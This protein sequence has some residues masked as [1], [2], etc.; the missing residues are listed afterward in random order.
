[1][2][3]KGVATMERAAVLHGAV[4]QGA[5]KPARLAG[6]TY[7][8]YPSDEQEQRFEQ[9]AGCCRA[10][11]NA[12]LEQRR[13]AWKLQRLSIWANQQAG[14]LPALKRDP[15]FAWLAVVPPSHT[16]QQ[17]L[18]DLDV[19]YRRFFRGQGGFPKFK[20]KGAGDSFRIPQPC[21][22][23]VRKLNRKWAEVRVPK[24]GW[25]RF[26]LTRPIGGDIRNAT[27]SKTAHGWQV[28]FCVELAGV[29]PRAPKRAV[30]LDRGVVITIA[31]SDGETLH[32]PRPSKHQAERRLRLE[33]KLSRQRKGSGG[34][35]RTKV[36]LAKHRATQARRS[37]DFCH[38]A[39]TEIARGYD[40]VA[41]EDLRVKNMTRSAKGSLEE[42][43][44]NV[45][46][47][48]GLNRGILEQC[49]GEIRR[50]LQYKTEWHGGALV[51]VPAAYS[52]LTC[53]RCNH[54]EG[55]NRKSQAVFICVNCGHERNADIN[56]ARV[57]LARARGGADSTA[58]GQDV[59]ARGAFGI[60]R[61]VKR[62][63]PVKQALA[64]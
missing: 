13:V 21:D 2:G 30:G 26:R 15:D 24:T 1:M 43:G 53:S 40:L 39:T 47:K 6:R 27:F 11:W 63:P 48:S 9:I 31:T 18:R 52:S 58:D 59:A 64:A 23:P 16:L 35:A 20:R 10:I 7:R 55:G 28:S 44:K 34:R 8:L 25:C 37:R 54:V 62:E 41:I 33:R 56:A 22:V 46:A 17:T 14:E 4:L 42:P 36:Q 57:I 60:G 45:A 19:A 38:K 12:A 29:L 51:E 5:G 61:A 49:W 3:L 32:A 50:Q